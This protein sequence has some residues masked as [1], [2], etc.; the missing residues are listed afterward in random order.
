MSANNEIQLVPV[1][2]MPQGGKLMCSA[3][4][5]HMYV[6]NGRQFADWIKQRI[7]ESGAVAG[8]D[9]TVHKFVN[10]KATRI[11]YYVTP[12]MGQE[13]GMLERNDKGRDPS[14]VHS[15]VQPASAESNRVTDILDNPAM[16]RELMLEIMARHEQLRNSVG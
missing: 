13:L 4:D 7:A 15:T 10:R 12:E 6:E 3:R 1:K 14:L 11:E 8:V 2:E 9:F 5:I 16:Q